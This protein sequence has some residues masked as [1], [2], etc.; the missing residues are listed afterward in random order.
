[1]KKQRGFTLIELLVVIAIIALLMAILMPALSK[2]K[3]QA[4]AVVCL[5]N[6]HQWS[7][8]WKMFADDNEGRLVAELQ[9]VKPVMSHCDD[10]DLLKCPAA[11]RPREPVTA[12]KD[13]FGRKFHAWVRWED[14][15]DNGTYETYFIGSYGYNQW[16]AW[17]TAGEGRRFEEGLWKTVSMK[18]V[19]YAP[20]MLDGA[21]DG[22]TPWHTDEPPEYDGQI[23]ESTPGDENEMRNF[24]INRHYEAINGLFGDWSARRIG[25]KELWELK[26]QRKW[27]AEGEPPPA[28]F[29]DPQHWTYPMKDYAGL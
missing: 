15:D 6:L 1:M 17:A 23:Y 2:A 21:R 8:V 13:R 26:W 7:L 3:V 11:A 28:E 20:L 29:Y 14:M 4:K 16:W 9:W 12:Q 18:G 22:A 27:N 5:S 25:L 10:A 24:C 19:A